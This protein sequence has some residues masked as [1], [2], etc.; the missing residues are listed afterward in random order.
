M[1]KKDSKFGSRMEAD[2]RKS[3]FV[4]VAFVFFVLFAHATRVG[5][6]DVKT[7]TWAEFAP[8]IEFVEISNGRWEFT[9]AGRQLVDYIVVDVPARAMSIRTFYRVHSIDG[10]TMY[11]AVLNTTASVEVKDRNASV[12][13]M[14]SCRLAT[15]TECRQKLSANL[16][17]GV[18][19]QSL[20][21]GNS[22]Y[23]TGTM[24]ELPILA[25]LINTDGRFKY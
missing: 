4:T 1:I 12:R 16:Q 7:V 6:Q 13:V 23:E 14:F 11:L 2:M 22:G 18:E 17:S 15:D 10:L 24:P 25:F 9:H 3:I 8:S 5:A 20:G 21:V 19:M